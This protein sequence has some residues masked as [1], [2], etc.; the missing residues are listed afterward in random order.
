VNRE[1]CVPVDAI[2]QMFEHTFESRP[3]TAH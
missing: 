3:A 2:T 1:P